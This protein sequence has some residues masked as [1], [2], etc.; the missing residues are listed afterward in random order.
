[1]VP[2]KDHVCPLVELS[3]SSSTSFSIVT[4]EIWSKGSSFELELPVLLTGSW[5]N[6]SLDRNWKKMQK[7]QGRDYS[8]SNQT[9]WESNAAEVE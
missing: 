5:T 7:T 4:R 6:S 9:E 2:H 8:W 1:M 3:S